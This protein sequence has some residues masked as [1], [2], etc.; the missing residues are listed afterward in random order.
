MQ[1]FNPL[2]AYMQGQQSRQFVDERRQQNALRQFEA[3]NG[4][5]LMAGDQNALNEYAKVG[6]LDNALAIR[7]QS[8]QAAATAQKAEREAAMDKMQR[9]FAV[10]RSADSPEA[11]DAGERF[12]VQNGIINEG[13]A[14]GW[15]FS[16]RDE[17]MN[18]ALPLMDQIKLE[19]G[20]DAVEREQSRWE[21]EFALKRQKAA[22]GPAPSALDRRAAAAGLQPG[23]PEYQKFMLNGGV[24][25][26][27]RISFDENGN[28]VIERGV[29]LEGAPPK[30][31]VDAAK[32]TGFYLRTQEAHQVLSELESEGTDFWQQVAGNLPMGVGNFARSPEFQRYDQARRDFVNAILRRESGA[33]I[34]D[35]E[36][37]NADKQYFPQPGDSPEVIAQKRRNR[38]T[39]IEGVR[40]GAGEGSSYVDGGGENAAPSGPPAGIEQNIWDAMSDEDKALF[41]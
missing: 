24:P 3:E 18:M 16:R 10:L 38:E 22:A 1:Q 34:A 35:S 23:T 15:D 28:P 21:A 31:T 29:G 27:E 37:D 33:V 32:N 40:V 25:R 13:D 39:A 41:Q 5:A 7:Q 8:A 11:W 30:M 14:Q 36:F 6:G 9:A 4:P 26:G 19:R 2:G 12:L 17:L 20:A